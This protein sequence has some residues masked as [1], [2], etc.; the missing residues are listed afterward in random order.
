[1]KLLETLTVC[2]NLVFYISSWVGFFFIGFFSAAVN[3]REYGFKKIIDL[4]P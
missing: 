4:E 3:Y 1:M 2:L